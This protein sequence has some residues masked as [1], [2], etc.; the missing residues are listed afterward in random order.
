[1]TRRILAV[2]LVLL[3]VV[4][5]CLPLLVMAG[6]SLVVH[7]HV[8][9]EFYTTLLTSKRTW[10]L[11]EH[12]LALAS[13]TTLLA[14]AVGVP[15]GLL[16][17]KTDLPFRKTLGVLVALPLLI[18][19]YIT[20]VCWSHVLGRE[21][22]LAT[23]L[24]PGLAAQT[25]AWL[26]GLPGCA[27]VLWSAFLPIVML[28]TMTFVRTINPSLEEA[29]TLVSGWFG[30]LSG[31][32]TPLI[33]PGIVLA[34]VLVFLL[35]L[36]EFSVPA[37]LR[38]D[39]FSV[40]SFT[41]F[42]AFHD[43]AAAT[44]AAVLLASITLLVFG[45]ERLSGRRHAYQLRPAP[46]G[47]PPAVIALGRFRIASLILISLLCGL[48]VLVPLL[49]LV[50]HSASLTAYAEAFSRAGDSLLRSLW[51][52][53][54]GSSLL[55]G[56]GFLLG[57]FIQRATLPFWQGL[58]FLTLVLFA[59]PSTVLGIGLVSLWNRP[60]TAWIYATPIIVVLGYLAQ[61]LALT[62]RITVSTLAQIPPSMEEAAQIV[63]AGWVR[64]LSLILAPLAR[65]GLAATWLVGY[66]FCLRDTGV[67][68][69][70]YPPGGDTLPVR[71]FTLMANGSSSLIAALC[72]L[73]VVTTAIP[74]GVLG[75]VVRP[76]R[77][78]S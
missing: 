66:I 60:A 64:R 77:D 2:L 21:G 27:L 33:R 53:A 15:V 8:S 1:M 14:L 34:A 11:L 3:F 51:Y 44:A 26:F 35:S 13:I 74:L 41:Q 38:Y 62:S 50:I 17:A 37:F 5:G 52:A 58:D 43:V 16:L 45:L 56:F 19:P 25:A 65:H 71:I 32:T 57:Y 46:D 28:L 18:P 24:G 39:V 36:G 75:V 73:M 7:D 69:M 48:V 10:V 68:M 30:V 31:I 55:T 47:A 49:V 67:T 70:V 72:V 59:L 61:Y 6:Q 22:L 78:V 54:I 29:G 4:I 40:E 20:A 63:G 9:A 76:A 42:S 12:S 23:W